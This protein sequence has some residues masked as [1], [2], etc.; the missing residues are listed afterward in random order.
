MHKKEINQLVL[1]LESYIECWK[2]FHH[3]LSLGR[4]KKFDAELEQQFLEVKSVITQELE[5]ILAAVECTSPSRSEVH[6]LIC[7][8][9]SIRYISEL[10]EGS[11][12]S[13]ENQWH[14]AYIG[15]QSM[16]GQLKV[17]QRHLT[18]EPNWKS[19]FHKE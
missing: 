16:L 9:P 12:R 18:S 6:Q 19:W 8:A 15:W 1:Q 2:Q 10:S 3:Y 17:R 5:M 7:N 11:L 13:L 14:K 4:T